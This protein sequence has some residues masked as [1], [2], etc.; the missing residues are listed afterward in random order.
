LRTNCTITAV[1]ERSV[2][3]YTVSFDVNGGTPTI[4]NQTVAYGSKATK[5][6]NPT[7]A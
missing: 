2:N 1:F 7:K 3:E 6:A 4:A 5:P